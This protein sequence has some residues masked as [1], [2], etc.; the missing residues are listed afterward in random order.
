MAR[1]MVRI[2]VQPTHPHIQL[3]NKKILL[4]RLRLAIVKPSWVINTNWGS[5]GLSWT[6]QLNPELGTAQPQLVLSKNTAVYPNLLVKARLPAKFFNHLWT[7][8]V[9]TNQKPGQITVQTDGSNIQNPGT[10]LN[11]IGRK[12]KNYMVFFCFL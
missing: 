12:K 9:S 7:R 3:G 5:V 11:L 10:E 6:S 1:K 2:L 8:Q 4:T